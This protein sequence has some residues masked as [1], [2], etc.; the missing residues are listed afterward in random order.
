M[1]SSLPY[2]RGWRHPTPRRT[3]TPCPRSRR[4]R[5][6]H[7]RWTCGRCPSPAGS[8]LLERP[9]MVRSS[10]VNPTISER[11]VGGV[12]VGGGD[13]GVG[14]SVGVLV[15]VGVGG[16]G[17]SRV[18]PRFFATSA[19]SLTSL[20]PSGTTSARSFCRG[21]APPTAC[22]P[23]RSSRSVSGPLLADSPP[24]P[25]VLPS[26]TASTSPADTLTTRT[27][28][29][30]AMIVTRLSLIICSRDE[31]RSVGGLL[32]AEGRRVLGDAF[33]TTRAREWMPFPGSQA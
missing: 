9:G 2:R 25:E 3:G 17:V 33:S 26:S 19:R 29:S 10:S 16:G 22:P 21:E 15:G 32:S 12:G 11:I 30:R 14:V 18:R 6:T 4:G 1:G 23:R 27:A 20:T 7:P 5:A 28:A 24:W 13:V 31:G 8:R